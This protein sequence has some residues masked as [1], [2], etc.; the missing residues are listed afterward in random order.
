MKF[1]SLQT[2]GSLGT[3]PWLW[4]EQCF[5][6]WCI[7]QRCTPDDDEVEVQTTNMMITSGGDIIEADPSSRKTPGNWRHSPCVVQ[8]VMMWW[9]HPKGISLD[10]CSPNRSCW[11]GLPEFP[12]F[13]G[14]VG[15]CWVYYEILITKWFTSER[16]P[17]AGI[18]D[19]NELRRDHVF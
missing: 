5:H 3:E 4:D 7:A 18:Q 19:T 14:N 1:I 12:C 17:G 10:S 13:V 15:L 2:G 9:S 16:K 11:C 6:A 8:N